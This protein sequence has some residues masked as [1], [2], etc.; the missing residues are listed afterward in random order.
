MLSFL[1][2]LQ[3]IPAFLSST[4]NPPPFFFSSPFF[5]NQPQPDLSVSK[6]TSVGPFHEK[7]IPRHPH[8]RHQL[9]P[10]R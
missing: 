8:R 2:L 9:H 1:L 7:G 10:G 6:K 4:K 3:A 5:S